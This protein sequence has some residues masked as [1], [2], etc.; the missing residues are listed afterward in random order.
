MVTAPILQPPSAEFGWFAPRRLVQIGT[1]DPLRLIRIIG[2]NLKIRMK[3][4][5]E[6]ASH[7]R[8]TTVESRINA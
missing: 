8:A 4:T 1:C 7:V 5:D 3:R 2:R 6:T